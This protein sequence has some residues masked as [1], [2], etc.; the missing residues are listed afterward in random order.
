MNTSQNELQSL[1]PKQNIRQK[2]FNKLLELI[3]K[4]SSTSS[5]SYDVLYKRIL[6]IERGLFNVTLKEYL[7]GNKDKNWNSLFETCYINKYINFYNNISP[8]SKINNGNKRLINDI[9]E[10]RINEFVLCNMQEKELNP[11]RWEKLYKNI[12]KNIEVYRVPE[13]KGEGLFRCGKCKTYKTTY[14]Q[15]QIRSADEP[16]STFVTCLGCGNRWRFN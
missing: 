8:D 16:M 11:E 15:L 4:Y 10:G 14:Y 1:L 13:V 3:V 12:T 6:N 2:V 7:E 5:T 9:I